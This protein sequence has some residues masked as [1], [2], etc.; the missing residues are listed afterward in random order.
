[1]LRGPAREKVQW[2]LPFQKMTNETVSMKSNHLLLFGSGQVQVL[3]VHF[4]DILFSTTIGDKS[5]LGGKWNWAHWPTAIPDFSYS[6]SRLIVLQLY[7]QWLH[8]TLVCLHIY[9]FC[10]QFSIQFWQD[11][12][13]AC[14]FY[15]SSLSGIFK[16]YSVQKVAWWNSVFMSAQA[17]SCSVFP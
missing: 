10:F 8:K 17:S 12:F 3:K 5:C 14:L 9:T 7:V 6:I 15:V 16:C 2:L 11:A 1:M 13:C 4:C